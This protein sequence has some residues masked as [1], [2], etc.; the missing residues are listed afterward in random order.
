MNVGPC[1]HPFGR[2]RQQA[3]E[4]I[5]IGDDDPALLNPDIA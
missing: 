1:K 2:F 4:R 3:G 5:Q